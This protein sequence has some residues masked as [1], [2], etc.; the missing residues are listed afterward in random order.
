M[1]RPAIS[2]QGAQ[3]NAARESPN[4]AARR[5]T[6]AKSVQC[7][8]K[9]EESFSLQGDNA[10]FLPLGTGVPRALRKNANP[11]DNCAAAQSSPGSL[12]AAGQRIGGPQFLVVSAAGT[13]TIVR[14]PS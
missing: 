8:A 9:V 14:A 2:W 3:K 11:A 5:R 12:F 13:A 1:G 7:G 10:L 6:P 4:S